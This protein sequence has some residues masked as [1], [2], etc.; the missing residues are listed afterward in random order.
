MGWVE[1]R[2]GSIFYLH[3][4]DFSRAGRTAAK[5]RSGWARD[6]GIKIETRGVASG[7]IKESVKIEISHGALNLTGDETQYRPPG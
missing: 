4:R 2:S 3:N 6:I 7:R 1:I 5:F